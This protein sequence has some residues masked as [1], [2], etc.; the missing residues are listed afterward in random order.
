MHHSRPVHLKRVS[1]RL[2][3]SEIHG[4]WMGFVKMSAAILPTVREVT[5]GLL[6][7]SEQAKMTS[8]L[9]ALVE[10]GHAV[11]VVYLTGHWLDIDTE[12]DLLDAENF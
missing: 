4:E 11:R 5:A 1:K 12:D 7:T 3:D 8:L 6:A 2:D 9:N 10:Q